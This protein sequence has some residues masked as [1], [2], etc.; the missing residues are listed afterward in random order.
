MES[1]YKRSK[2]FFDLIYGYFFLAF[3]ILISFIIVRKFIIFPEYIN[4]SKIVFVLITILLF[5]F[6]TF[7]FLGTALIRKQYYR[8]NLKYF[9][10]LDSKKKKSFLMIRKILKRD[11]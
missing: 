3:T 5:S 11:F 4:F 8:N 2:I 9:I 6:L 10:K 7:L 1:E